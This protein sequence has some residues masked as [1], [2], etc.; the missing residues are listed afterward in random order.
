MSI[1]QTI[2]IHVEI[3][4]PVNSEV[5]TELKTPQV[6][7]DNVT[8][9]VRAELT[10]EIEPIDTLIPIEKSLTRKQNRRKTKTVDKTNN[11]TSL[12]INYDTE[13]EDE[14]D[15]NTRMFKLNKNM[16]SARI[17]RDI[18]DNV[19]IESSVKEKIAEVHSLWVGHH[20]VQR[21]IN[22]LLLCGESWPG[23]RRDVREFIEYCPACQ[24]MSRLKRVINVPRYVVTTVNPMQRIAVDTV[25]P[26][27][28]DS[29]G[30][31]YVL[32][33][34]DSFTR[35]TE[36][37]PMRNKTAKSAAR[38]ILQ[39][40]GRFGCPTEILSD[41]GGEFVNAIIDGLCRYLDIGRAYIH[42]GSHQENGQIE[43][44]N[45]EMSQHLIIVAME[46]NNKTSWVDY[47]PIVQRIL[48]STEFGKL[49]STPAELLF[50]SNV[51][52]D[53]HFLT[54]PRPTKVEKV[55]KWLDDFLVK[56][57]KRAEE[58]RQYENKRIKQ[59]LN[60]EMKRPNEKLTVFAVNDRI[61]V[62]WPKNALTGA[63]SKPNRLN[64][65]RRGPFI[66]VR[67]NDNNTYD[68]IHAATK[69]P[70]TFSIWEMHPYKQT[71]TNDE[72]RVARADNDMVVITSV[73]RHRFVTNNHIM[74]HLQLEVTFGNGT[75]IWQTYDTLK[76]VEMVHEY[77][78]KH[79]LG[80]LLA[81]AFRPEEET[82]PSKKQR[83]QR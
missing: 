46:L 70:E 6:E 51:N 9:E 2:P 49:G 73:R 14:V 16:S 13:A 35:W 69:L 66:V 21:T 56:H 23:M 27:E 19:K 58:A 12:D 24:K 15:R 47:L 82:K 43:R 41:N 36:L 45:K 22:K 60:R 80:Y 3:D 61:L 52:L 8:S 40:V 74:K 34:T 72:D 38:A 5:H 26:F 59:Q 1:Q 39:F 11:E 81:K 42:P 33:I 64:T 31:E 83:T 65:P 10:N 32:V 63:L 53:R 48:N 7:T 77:L 76:R 30:Y 55:A 37:V 20:G 57:E 67:K 44:T 71:D 28:K 68:V 4:A 50:G 79:R 17:E 25:G 75:P 78:R 54:S 29:E 18:L 62:D